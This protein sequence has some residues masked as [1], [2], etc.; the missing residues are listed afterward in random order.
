MFGIQLNSG[1]EASCTLA[2]IGQALVREPDVLLLD[3][4]TA[5]IDGLS[6]TAVHD[7]IRHQARERAVLTIAHRLST[8]VDADTIIVMDRGRIVD[9]GR[10]EDLLERCALYRRLVDSLRLDAADRD[11]VQSGQR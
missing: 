9:H 6:E 8:V 10:H 5:Q 1:S 7:V 4:V 11:A 2:A 3:E